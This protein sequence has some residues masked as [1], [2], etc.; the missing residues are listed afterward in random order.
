MGN[1]IRAIRRG[2][3]AG[4]DA[5]QNP[6]GYSF[7]AAGK[8]IVCPHCDTKSFNWV[9]VAGISVAGYGLECSHCT[10]LLYFARRPKQLD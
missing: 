1:T 7:E 8:T 10:H 6:H 2:I 4:V 5:V 9:G 3:K